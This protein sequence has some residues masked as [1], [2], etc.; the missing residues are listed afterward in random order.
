MSQAHHVDGAVNREDN[1][2]EEKLLPSSSGTT[3]TRDPHVKDDETDWPDVI[4]KDVNIRGGV[5]FH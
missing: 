2:A 3:R 4:E 5:T 1:G